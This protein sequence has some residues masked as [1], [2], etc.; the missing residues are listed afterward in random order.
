MPIGRAK[1]QYEITRLTIVIKVSLCPRKDPIAEKPLRQVFEKL[2][3]ELKVQAPLLQQID[4]LYK[5]QL[6]ALPLLITS[7]KFKIAIKK[8]SLKLKFA[9]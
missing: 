4:R 9:A 3:Q 1:N 5:A 7:K 2:P 8:E 6:V